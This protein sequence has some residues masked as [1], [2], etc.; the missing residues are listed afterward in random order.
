[1]RVF[2]LENGKKPIEAVAGLTW[3]PLVPDNFK[4]EFKPLAADLNADLYVYRRSNKSMVGFART[5]DGAAVGQVPIALV[6]AQCLDEESEPT[7]ALV[8]VELPGVMTGS[9]PTYL[10]VLIRD[11]FVLADGDLVGTEEQIKSRY[12]ADLSVAGWDLLIA[13]ANWDVK[14]AVSRTLDSFIPTKGDKVNIPKTWKLQSTSVS[15]K[16]PLMGAVLICC[17]AV[18]GYMGLERWK[19]MEL[20]AMQA[21]AAAEQAA[22][23]QA[24]QQQQ[25]QRDPWADLPRVKPFLANCE[26]GLRTIGV[27]AGNWSLGGFTCEKGVLSVKWERAGAS[28][29]V[30]HLMALHPKAELDETGTSATVSTTLKEIPASLS[31]NEPLPPLNSRMAFLRDAKLRYGIDITTPNNQKNKDAAAQAPAPAAEPAVGR[32][33]TVVEVTADSKLSLAS[34]AEILDA[35]GYRVTRLEGKMKNGLITYQLKGIQYAKP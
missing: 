29:L 1:M 20:E 23:D 21:R 33:W 17:I 32:R 8:A 15:L 27:T 7:N 18:A 28:A 26:A 31:G 6:I 3:H 34:T 25:E 14:N 11:G 12:L 16:V 22:E 35:P 30:A 2:E 24:R 9:E 10:Y 4:K 19:R 5:E 13:P